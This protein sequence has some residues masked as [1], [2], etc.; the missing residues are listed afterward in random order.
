MTEETKKETSKVEE[1]K[2]STAADKVVLDKD[3]FEAL[4]NRIQVLEEKDQPIKKLKKV[5]EHFA[6]LR[7]YDGFYLVDFGKFTTKKVD[8]VKTMFLTVKFQNIDGKIKEDEVK[9]VEFF[10]ESGPRQKVKLIKRLSEEV[11]Q[12]QDT[13]SKVNLNEHEQKKFIGGEVDLDVISYIDEYE[14]E[15]LEGNLQGKRVNVKANVLNC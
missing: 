7:E 13:I 5:D 9:Y 14:V 10:A 12:T 6:Y 11:V 15:F 8:D 1:P 4:L 3:Q 2:V